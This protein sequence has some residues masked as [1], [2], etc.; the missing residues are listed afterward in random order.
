MN[1][2]G[3][4]YRPD[5]PIPDVRGPG[6]SPRH[7][8]T[9][10]RTPEADR[11]GAGRARL[12]E[13]APARPATFEI[14]FGDDKAVSEKTVTTED[15]AEWHYGDYEGLWT[16]EIKASRAERGLD[17]ERAWDVCRDGCE[18]GEYVFCCPS[19]VSLNI[20]LAECD[21]SADQVSAR[22]DKL[23]S[24]IRNVQRPGFNG[25]GPCDVVLVRPS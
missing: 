24:E 2:D 25:E 13:A 18:G 4:I 15:I 8:G 17:K 14:L 1:Q 20:M 10:G 6:P 23:I 9:A 22:L 19:S 21:R 5:G 12:G 16:A 11:P 3:P 7:R